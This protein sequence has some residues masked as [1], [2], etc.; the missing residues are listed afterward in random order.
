MKFLVNI[1]PLLLF[2]LLI[3]LAPSPVTA[4]G[5]NCPAGCGQ[6]APG[7]Y[8]CGNNVP[9]CQTYDIGT[10]QEREVCHPA[11]S[12]CAWHDGCCSKCSESDCCG[13]PVGGGTACGGGGGEQAPW[14]PPSTDTG[15]DPACASRCGYAGCGCGGCEAGRQMTGWSECR[16]DGYSCAE[17]SRCD[18]AGGEERCQQCNYCSYS[19]PPAPSLS[20]PANGANL[21]YEDVTFSWSQPQRFVDG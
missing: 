1:F 13:A 2:F 3:H 11:P 17:F 18:R 15:T 9:S 6:T 21:P 16:P 5:G 7:W 4:Q 19:G 12:S 14:T 20:S 10:P 8:V